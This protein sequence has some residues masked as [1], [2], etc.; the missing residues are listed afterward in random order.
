MNIS[1]L[2]KVVT[3]RTIKAPGLKVLN[4]KHREYHTQTH[5]EKEATEKVLGEATPDELYQ[6]QL[7]SEK[8]MPLY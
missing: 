8:G 6:Q 4:I 2:K 1:N 7:E 3:H 5:A